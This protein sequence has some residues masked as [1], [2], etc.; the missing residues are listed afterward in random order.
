MNRRMYVFAL[1]LSTLF[2]TDQL[3]AV[4][5]AKVAGPATVG[6]IGG[7]PAAGAPRAGEAPSPGTSSVPEKAPRPVDRAALTPM[8][9]EIF[10]A[11]ETERKQIEE[12][13]HRFTRATLPDEKFLIQKEIESVKKH[14]MIRVFEIQVSYARAAGHEE[15]AI[16]LEAAIDGIRNPKRLPGSGETMLERAGSPGVK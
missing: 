11:V 10:D 5:P 3:H 8:Q 6:L 16:R 7:S 4:S 1:A 2:A 15:A 13:N 12:L 14:G 9:R